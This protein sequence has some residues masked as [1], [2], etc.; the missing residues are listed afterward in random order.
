MDHRGVGGIDDESA[1]LI[2][3]TRSSLE[4]AIRAMTVGST[5][6]AIGAAVSEVAEAAGMSE[7]LA[8]LRSDYPQGPH[9]QPQSM[10]PAFGSLRVGL[11]MRR[12]ATILSGSACCVYGLTFTSHFYGARRSVGYVPDS[13]P[14][15]N[16][17]TVHEYLDFYARAY[18]LHG[19][20]RREAVGAVE[21]FTGV[22]GILD[23]HLKALSK[24]MKQR[25]TL[26]RALIHNPDVLILDEP[27]AGLDPRARVELRELLAVLA[28]DFMNLQSLS[29]NK[30][31]AHL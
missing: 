26:G 13:L 6:G 5:L 11:R 17:V 24:G 3:V 7:T 29:P 19:A 12:T 16:D 14:A 22:T 8:Q 4:A 15:H 27:A 28:T 25:V 18:G 20:K 30:I 23:K 1:R 31:G 10:C 9:D 21:E 2:E